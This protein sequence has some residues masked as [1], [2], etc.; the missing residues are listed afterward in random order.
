MKECSWLNIIINFICKLIWCCFGLWSITYALAI[1]YDINITNINTN[2]LL[3]GFIA[4]IAFIF[5]FYSYKTSILGI[6]LLFL[7]FYRLSI[8]YSGFFPKIIIGFRIIGAEFIKKLQNIGYIIEFDFGIKNLPIK[9][10]EYIINNYTQTAILSLMIFISA[11]LSLYAYKKHR[12]FLVSFISL[13]LMLPGII[14]EFMPSILIFRF[15]LSFLVGLFVMNLLDRIYNITENTKHLKIKQALSNTVS[16]GKYVVFVFIISYVIS[17]CSSYIPESVKFVNVS[18]FEKIAKEISISAEKNVSLIRKMFDIRFRGNIVNGN[19][20]RGG[21]KYYNYPVMDVYS[22]STMPIY[23]R[24]W[25]S[26]DYNSNKWNSFSEEEMNEYLNEFSADF[27]PEQITWNFFKSLSDIPDFTKL[28]DNS[29][30]LIDV[31]TKYIDINRNLLYIPSIAIDVPNYFTENNF[32]NKGEGMVSIDSKFDVETGYSLKAIMPIYSYEFIGDLITYGEHSFNID[33]NNITIEQK[34]RQFV[35]SNYVY[36]PTDLFKRISNLAM[37]ITATANATNNFEKVLSIQ[38]YLSKNYTYNLNPPPI[39]DNIDFVEHFL[40]N[41]KE[42]YCTYYASAMVLMLRS[43]G[44]PARYVE[45]YLVQGDGIKSEGLYKRTVLDSDAHAWPEVYFDGVGWLPFEPTVTFT[46]ELF[47]QKDEFENNN[48]NF[49]EYEEEIK[50]EQKVVEEETEEITE[51]SVQKT[52]ELSVKENNPLKNYNIYIIYIIIFIVFILVLFIVY[53]F[54]K[55]KRFKPNTVEQI[56]KNIFEQLEYMK[57]IRQQGELPTEFALRVDKK[58]SDS[59]DI[60]F[61]DITKIALKARFSKLDI[62]E[63]ELEILKKYALA[64]S[65]ISYQKAN[66][67]KKLWFL[68]LYSIGT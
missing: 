55:I 11:I 16:H 12:P 18:S 22:S 39:P 6:I 64:V 38:N 57:I 37:D 31:R 54:I 5:M 59:T 53:K 27:M 9:L 65:K 60:C 48:S 56:I 14:Y 19:L 44:I 29:I 4:M 32:K 52:E 67:F 24:R 43:I 40:F 58:I 21:F 23:L 10:N 68:L 1:I 35:Y 63:N 46:S 34:Y 33:K 36:L 47:A 50:T 2:I 66:V 8:E 30:S 20:G 25:I 26:K 17:I 41:S 62:T 3:Y 61:A 7:L 15:I 45:G 51:V 28:I 13:L 49:S 42:G